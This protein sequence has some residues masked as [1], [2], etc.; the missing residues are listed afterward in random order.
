MTSEAHKE[1][2]GSRDIITSYNEVFEV[3]GH[4]LKIKESVD[5]EKEDILG[6]TVLMDAVSNGD[7]ELVKMLVNAGANINHYNKH[8]YTPLTYAVCNH[9][10]DLI[11]LLINLGS[12][13][14]FKVP[15]EDQLVGKT[16][17]A[18]H[19]AVCKKD[20][21]IMQ[22]LLNAGA[23]VN[24]ENINAD[25]E[26]EGTALHIV[27]MGGLN[28]LFKDIYTNARFAQLQQQFLQEYLEKAN[29]LVNA[30]ADKTIKDHKGHTAYDIAIKWENNE[31][32]E[33]I[34]PGV[35]SS[36]MN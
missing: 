17:F 25:D 8:M 24:R 3:C 1:Y 34:K 6:D 13:V 21:R 16:K 2:L 22:V 23:D 32:A 28:N 29:I 18:L 11:E 7:I 27:A 4:I 20:V 31:I 35:Y 15:N 12:D 26:S 9:G 5:L 14:N 30:G 36:T 10:P 19:I 33:I